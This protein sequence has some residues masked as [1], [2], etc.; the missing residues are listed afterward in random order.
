MTRNFFFLEN[1]EVVVY[2]KFCNHAS[3]FLAHK[4]KI[5]DIFDLFIKFTS[6][7][8]YNFVKKINS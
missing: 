6:E 5:W 1:L 4:I 3:I 8:E 7:R 2:I